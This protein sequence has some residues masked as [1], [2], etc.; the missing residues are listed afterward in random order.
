MFSMGT[1]EEPVKVLDS[2][3]FLRV[4][5]FKYF[6]RRKNHLGYGYVRV[7]LSRGGKSTQLSSLSKCKDSLIEDASSKSKS[8]PVK[9][10]L[11]KSLNIFGLKYTYL[12]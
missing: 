8:H 10:Y 3:F 6:L 5:T 11:S 12:K 7:R 9:F 1:A 4:Y 2:T